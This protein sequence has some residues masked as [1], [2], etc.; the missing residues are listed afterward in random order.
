VEY[1]RAL[2]NAQL[3]Y[4]DGSGHNAYQDEPK[5]YMD[6]VRAFLLGRPLPE[7]QYEGSRRPDDYDG[8]P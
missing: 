6:D 5:R 4:L 7:R 2:P 3:L 8:P 1:L